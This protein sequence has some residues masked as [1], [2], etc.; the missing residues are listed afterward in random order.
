VVAFEEV[1]RIAAVD[2]GA[3]KQL[4]RA[5]PGEGRRPP[6][7]PVFRYDRLDS[8]GSR[9]QAADMAPFAGPSRVP[10]RGGRS[11]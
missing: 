10:T 1:A 8:S 7:P 5:R 3:V 9:V 4:A 11:G 2:T 6:P